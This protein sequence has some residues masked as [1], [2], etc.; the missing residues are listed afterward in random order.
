ME[1]LFAEPYN[2]VV[3]NVIFTLSLWHAFAKLQMHTQTTATQFTEVT[4][5]LGQE[6]QRF[7]RDMCDHFMMKALPREAAARVRRKAKKFYRK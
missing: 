1:G 4:K 3:L 6:I 5:A 2:S 7:K